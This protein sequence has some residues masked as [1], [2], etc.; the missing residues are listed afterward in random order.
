MPDVVSD[1]GPIIALAQ[2]GQ[3]ER[4]RDTGFHMSDTLYDQVLRSAG[5]P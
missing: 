5:E 1:T 3:L 2:I 4:L